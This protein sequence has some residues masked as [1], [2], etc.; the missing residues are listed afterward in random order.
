MKIITAHKGRSIVQAMVFNPITLNEYLVKQTKTAKDLKITM[1][2][3]SKILGITDL[4]EIYTITYRV[5][6]GSETTIYFQMHE[7]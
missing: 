3:V 6:S 2:L 5:L 7:V 4:G 1:H